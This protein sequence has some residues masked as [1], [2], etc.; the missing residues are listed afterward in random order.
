MLANE[1]GETMSINLRELAGWV[2]TALGVLLIGFVLMMAL[3]RHVLEAFALSLPATMVFRSGI[4]L[5]RLSVALR[6][7]AQPPAGNL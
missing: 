5:V 6:V 3:E 4:G 2:L 7:A 1:R